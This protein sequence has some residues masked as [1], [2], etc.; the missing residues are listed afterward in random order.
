[1]KIWL[2]KIEND[3][4]AYDLLSRAYSEI[5]SEK[6]PEIRKT[7]E[8]KPYFACSDI[9]FSLSHSGDYAACVL[10]DAPVGVDIQIERNTTE[11]LKKRILSARENEDFFTYWC[12]K[13]SFI[14][15]LGTLDREY[16]EME[17]VRDGEI[18]AGP[19]GVYGRAF[20][21]EDGYTLAVCAFGMAKLDNVEIYKYY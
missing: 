17:F 14:K 19:D 20:K 15:L 21:P 3:R 9:H 1:M 12:L 4:E 5:Y 16:A 11:H 2:C 13:E 7:S 6:M 18:F 8:G 10:S